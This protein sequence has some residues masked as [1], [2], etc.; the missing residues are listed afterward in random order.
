MRTVTVPTT[1][2]KSF[3]MRE[4]HAPLAMLRQVLSTMYFVANVGWCIA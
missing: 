3:L 4:I 1:V 2:E